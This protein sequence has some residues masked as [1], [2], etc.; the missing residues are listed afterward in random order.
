MESKTIKS[1]KIEGIKGYGVG[2][3]A[4]KI[5]FQD[6]HGSGL[7]PN[8][9]NIAVA[10]NGFGKSSLTIAISQLNNKA[11]CLEV[12]KHEL[13]NR[14]ETLSPCIELEFSG[15]Q[16]PT[17][18]VSDIKKNEIKDHFDVFTINS[19]LAAKGKGSLYGKATGE[20]IVSDVV[21]T[22][23]PDKKTLIF[24]ISELKKEFSEHIVN[25]ELV[26]KAD[27][28]SVLGSVE[29][30]K[31]LCELYKE[32]NTKNKQ[33]KL[34]TAIDENNVA[35]YQRLLD[36]KSASIVLQSFDEQCYLALVSL[37]L[38][39][40]CKKDYTQA[41]LKKI[42][43]YLEYRDLKVDL[44]EA[45]GLLR[46]FM[47]KINITETKGNLVVKFPPAAS[48]SNGQRDVLSF[49]GQL[50]SFYARFVRS[51]KE[52][53]LLII[54]EVF[55]YLD[56]ANLLVAHYY[57]VNFINRFKSSK[58]Y[59]YL[60]ILTHLEPSLILNGRFK[61]PKIFYL[62]GKPPRINDGIIK[63]INSRNNKKLKKYEFSRFLHFDQVDEMDLT[64]LF[65][66]LSLPTNLAKR[67]NFICTINKEFQGYI[68]QQNYCPV[69]TALYLRIMIEK[70]V[71]NRL[72]TEQQTEFVKTHKTIK[73][74]EYAVEQGVEVEELFYLLAP[75]YNEL[76]H[77]TVESLFYKLENK[78][79]RKLINEVCCF[80]KNEHFNEAK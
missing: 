54:D 35:G 50:F 80:N 46:T 38:G 65:N 13:D 10:P 39:Y 2:D 73:K 62:A 44:E 8:K 25:L 23:I 11:K 69:S 51:K 41:Y 78:V 20:L 75:I 45:I 22:K 21:I 33:R 40:F 79:V 53:S 68:K 61:K 24:S 70:I 48:I 4:K 6:S 3:N 7:I 56:D 64:E 60:I 29:D 74:L 77:K 72:D 71:F 52:S 18:L 34:F 27:F 42:V 32:F 67:N 12:S 26:T 30:L 15:S 14:D 5:V 31:L 17:R 37:A 63:C 57:L 59:V 58:K 55:D 49:I 16:T 19:L 1:I 9:I 76:A 43:S 36:I 66:E 47:Q 28:N